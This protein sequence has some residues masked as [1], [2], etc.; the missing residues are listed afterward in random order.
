MSD[1]RLRK[2]VKL[3]ARGYCNFLTGK[4]K[5]AEKD[6]LKS[7]KEKNLAFVSLL[8]GAQISQAQHL[9]AKKEKYLIKAK[10]KEV[11]PSRA[12]ETLRV[13]FHLE[14]NQPEEAL[15]SL[16]KLREKDPKDPYLLRLLTQTYLELKDYMP[17][18]RILIELKQ[19]KVFTQETYNHIEKETYFHCLQDQNFTD[20]STVQTLWNK[21]PKYLR[22]DP[23]IIIAYSNHLRRWNRGSEAEKLVQTELKK[24][25]HPGLVEYYAKLKSE[26]PAK[27]I[28]LGKK[29][30]KEHPDDPATLRA[31]GMLCL[32]NKLWGQARDYLEA[33]AKHQPTAEV[34]SALGFVYE[35]LGENE[36]A[37]Q[38][39]RKGLKFISSF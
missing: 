24:N 4:W 17:L 37:L 3:H 28:A 2:S 27:Q 25:Y 9:V 34:C 36:K 30:L 1:R 31:M 8:I 14:D 12:V 20:F 23:D 5:K 39:Y 18:Q 21:I 33:N 16:I 32:Q 11:Q 15:S 19:R 10:E 6:I 22:H 35:K 38:Y 26:E 29:W 7:A 13:K